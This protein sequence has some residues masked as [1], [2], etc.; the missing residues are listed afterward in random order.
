MRVDGPVRFDTLEWT[1]A[2]E[3]SITLKA[4]RKYVALATI[5][6]CVVVAVGIAAFGRRGFWWTICIGTPVVSGALNAARVTL[7]GGVIS[8]SGTNFLRHEI[9]R[10]RWVGSGV[11]RRVE[12]AQDG[13]KVLIVW[14]GLLADAGPVVEW[15]EGIRAW[16]ENDEPRT[17]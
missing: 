2:G 5:V 15:L 7:V 3:P 1:P 14:T 17:F 4:D 9:R 6:W 11:F 16:D 10:A 12:L 8:R 13:G